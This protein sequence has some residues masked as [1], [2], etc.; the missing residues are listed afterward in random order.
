MTPDETVRAIAAALQASADGRTARVHLGVAGRLYLE[1]D[2]DGHLEDITPDG[3][4]AGL[5][6]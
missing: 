6:P 5:T 1:T 4:P 3:I 2:G